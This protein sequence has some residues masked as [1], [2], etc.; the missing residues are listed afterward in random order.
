QIVPEQPA[1]L[2]AAAAAVLPPEARKD[3][4][5]R[6]AFYTATLR[7]LLKSQPFKGRRAML[8]IPGHQTLMQNIEVTTQEGLGVEL[9]VEAHLRDRLDIDPNRMVVRHFEAP[10]AHESSA[11]REVVVLAAPREAVI[12]Y[13][14]LAR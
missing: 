3:A 7:K 6:T 11:Q 4:A 14:N 2:V 1:Q 13:L 8:A 12:G 5:S 10:A 9:Q